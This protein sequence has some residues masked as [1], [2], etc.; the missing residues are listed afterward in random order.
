M[1]LIIILIK[2]LNLEFSE[3]YPSLIHTHTHPCTIT[4]ICNIVKLA[5][6]YNMLRHFPLR[7]IDPLRGPTGCMNTNRDTYGNEKNLTMVKRNM[8]YQVDQMFLTLSFGP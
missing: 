8:K 6:L 7:I 1:S 2:T 4:V 3:Y 5:T